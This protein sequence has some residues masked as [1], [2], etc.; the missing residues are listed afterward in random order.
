MA[1]ASDRYPALGALTCHCF[2]IQRPNVFAK[3]D[4]RQA[5]TDEHDCLLPF[6]SHTRLRQHSLLLLW[7][8]HL[9]ESCRR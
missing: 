6:Y 7:V 8:D 9:F 4:R 2:V 3:T 5:L 1:A